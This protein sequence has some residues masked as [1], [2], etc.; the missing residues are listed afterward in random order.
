MISLTKSWQVEKQMS[1]EL[2]VYQNIKDPLKFVSDFGSE[3]ARCGFYNCQ[4]EAQ[5]RV[6]ALACISEGVSPMYI[7]K[8]YHIIGGNLSMRSDAMLAEFNA[9]GGKHTINART[10]DEASVTLSIDGQNYTE[11]LSW[12]EA[13]QEPFVYERDK[14]TPKYNWATPRARRQM[15]WARVISEAVRTLRPGIVVGTYTPEEVSDFKDNGA[16]VVS[17]TV[18]PTPAPAP[19][20]PEVEEIAGESKLPP[21]AMTQ[22]LSG[23]VDQVVVDEIK[24]L[25]QK[26][27]NPQTIL[28]LQKFLADQGKAKIA[29]LTA[30]DADRLKRDLEIGAIEDFFDQP[31]SQEEKEDA[32]FEGSSETAV[33]DI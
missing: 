12:E 17:A 28:K 26:A 4:N 8:R 24:S 32:P 30:L 10:S 15:L 31:L 1:S 13:K 3:I 18:A 25:L 2:A 11:S 21:E 5:G 6:I 23:P 27:G 33:L 16:A 9:L 20:E 14:K 29:D 22:E 19:P 7:A